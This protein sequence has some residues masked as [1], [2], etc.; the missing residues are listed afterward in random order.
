MI[1]PKGFIQN[2]R[3]TVYNIAQI[4]GKIQFITKTLKTQFS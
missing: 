4:H 1:A 3:F 2:V